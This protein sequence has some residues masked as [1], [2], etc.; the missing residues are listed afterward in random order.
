MKYRARTK[1]KIALPT[2]A[3]LIILDGLWELEEGTVEEV[4]NRLPSNPRA[5]Y[6][7]VQS[8]LRIM[9]NKGFVQHKMRGRA[10]VFMPCVTRDEVGRLSAKRV[11]DRNFQG[12][13][14]AMLMNLLD[15]NHIREGELVE[16]E[17]LIQ[18]YR[19]RKT[20]DGAS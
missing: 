3:E 15:G 9:E 2:D 7:T 16:L 17:K 8:L 5:N 19:E 13:H 6:K 14:T 4:A 11:V 20:K 18:Q 12:S 10:F 1:V